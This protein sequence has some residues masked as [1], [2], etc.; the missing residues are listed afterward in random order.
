MNNTNGKTLIIKHESCDA[1]VFFDDNIASIQ[2]IFSKEQG[3]GHARKCLEKI[4]QSAKSKGIKEIWFPTVISPAL[5]H[6]LKDIGYDFVNFG[7]HPMMPD[8][9]DI[10]GF[11]KVLPDGVNG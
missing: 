3:K 10:Y 11:K 8:S 1:E 5:E 4:E 9:G 2:S 7:K 6:L